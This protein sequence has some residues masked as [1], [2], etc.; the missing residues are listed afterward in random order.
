MKGYKFLIFNYFLLSTRYIIPP[1]IRYEKK[2]KIQFP[3]NLKSKERNQNRD[4]RGLP[5]I[6]SILWKKFD[7]S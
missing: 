5:S 1:M 7:I 4:C 3:N 2:R 6:L